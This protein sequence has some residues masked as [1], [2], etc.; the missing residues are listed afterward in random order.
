VAEPCGLSGAS[1]SEEWSTE[2]GQRSRA[3]ESSATGPS[4]LP[5]AEPCFLSVGLNWTVKATAGAAGSRHQV[6]GGMILG[7]SF[8]PAGPSFPSSE[9]W[10]RAAP[11]LTGFLVG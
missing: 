7:D 6:A 10:R 5:Q 11:L 1:S 8:Q 2:S 4:G 9:R 3:G